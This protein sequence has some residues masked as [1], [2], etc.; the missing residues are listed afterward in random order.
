MKNTISALIM[1]H[2]EENILDSCLNKLQ[3]CDEIVIVLD[4]STDNSKKISEKYTNKI[5][6]GSWEYEGER[7]NF[8]ISKCSS[9]WVLEIDADEHVSK[10]LAEEITKN[11]CKEKNI[12]SNFHIKIHNFIG[13]K[14]IKFGWGGS[15]GR[16]GVTC[17]FKKG[18]KKWGKQ[19]V[20]PELKFEGSF[21]PDL[22]HPINHYFVKNI[23]ELLKKFDNW[24]FLK[25]LDLI[26]QNKQ[27]SLIRNIRRI[28]SRF[29]KNYYKR[30]GYKEGKL[31]FLIALLA[32]LF[33]LI[34]FLRAKIKKENNLQ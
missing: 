27:E 22:K 10:E 30:K 21:G 23:S 8:G 20:H 18:T 25:S 4:K 6:I 33:P 5:F 19:R 24:T 29:L 2:N 31:G 15:F 16:S 13:T 32:G 1:V 17:L 9:N 11:I 14:L 34:S 28:F 7:R 3:F 26:D 12:Y